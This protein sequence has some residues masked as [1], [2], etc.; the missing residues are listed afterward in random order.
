MCEPT[1]HGA[2]R[3]GV[4]GTAF[5]NRFP[6]LELAIDIPNQGSSGCGVS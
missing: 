1:R 5:F 2:L 3:D 4:Y 6:P